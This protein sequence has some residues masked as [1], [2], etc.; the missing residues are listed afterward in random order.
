MGPGAAGADHP[1]LHAVA[2]AAGDALLAAVT[3][4]T[5]AGRFPP[6]RGIEFL[7]VIWSLLHGLAGLVVDEQ[8]PREVRATVPVETLARGAI[9]VLLTGLLTRRTPSRRG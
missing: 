6:G 1:A 8:L 3:A 7:F 2:A 9:D 4:C 5:E